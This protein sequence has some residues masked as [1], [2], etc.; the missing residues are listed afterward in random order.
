MKKDNENNEMRSEYFRKDLG[1]GV[2]GKYYDAYKKSSNIVI[3]KPEV[4]KAFPT[5]DAVNQALLSLIRLAQISVRPE[6]IR[7]R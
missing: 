5:E 3:L 2:R 4:A 7:S 1:A 6:T